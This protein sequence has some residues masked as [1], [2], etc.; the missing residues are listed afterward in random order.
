M[1]ISKLKRLLKEAQNVWQ[2]EQA[3]ADI[4]GLPGFM[5]GVIKG[6]KEA[7]RIIETYQRQEVRKVL[8]ERRLASRWH[9]V[10]L[11]RACHQAYGRL[12]YSDREGALRALR[13]ALDKTKP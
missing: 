12:R 1:S 4:T 2:V 8:V 6:L 10:T 11:Y 5:P 13:R 3:N 7:L 9:A